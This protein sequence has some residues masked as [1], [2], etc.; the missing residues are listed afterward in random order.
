[1]SVVPSYRHLSPLRYPGGKSNYYAFLAQVIKEN[2]L[3]DCTYYE[4]YAGGAG[5]ALR[6][7]DSGYVSHIHLNDADYRIFYFW[8][9]VINQTERFI[10]KILKIEVSIDEWKRQRDIVDSPN[11]HGRFEIGFAT[12]LMNRCN[13]S[14][15]IKGSGPIGGLEQNSL[16]AIDAR[17]NRSGLAKRIKRIAKLGNAISL[18]N[19]DGINFLKGT[20]PRGLERKNTFI[21][22]DPPYVSMGSRLYLNDLTRRDHAILSKYLMLQKTVSWLLSYDN[23]DLIRNLYSTVEVREVQFRYSLNSH[24]LAKELIITPPHVCMS[25]RAT[26]LIGR[27]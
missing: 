5:A 16:Y 14:G 7:L 22:L 12:F 11:G 10:D 20:L 3:N 24:A 17:F 25:K 2:G 8:D 6:L 27:S 13:R 9:S 23:H 18:S 19:Q 4:P 26:K 15:I 21:Y 1:M